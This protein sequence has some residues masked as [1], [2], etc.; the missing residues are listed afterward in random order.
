[1]KMLFLCL[2]KRC[3]VGHNC[4][5]FTLKIIHKVPFLRFLHSCV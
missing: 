4:T 3:S 5:F 2:V 1:M